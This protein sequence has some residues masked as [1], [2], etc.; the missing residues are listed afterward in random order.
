MSELINNFE[1]FD[2]I[3][4]DIKKVIKRFYVFD[5]EKGYNVLFV[6]LND[7]VFG[8]GSNDC[9]VCGF[10][11]Q[12]VVKGPKII[13]ELCDKSVI[14]FYN[15]STFALALTRDNKL[16]GW[17][18]NQWGQLGLK[19]VNQTKL[20]KPVLIE[21]LN[22]I[23]IKQISCGS[24]HTLVLTSDGMVYGWGNN[25]YGQIG[26]G[27]EL[28]E[29]ISVIVKLESLHKIETIHCSYCSSFALT[30]NGMVYSWGHNNWCHLG[31]ESKQNEC[32]FNPKLIINLQNI[33]SICSSNVNT[34]FLSNE[35]EIY[36]CGVYYDGNNEQCFQ[37]LP[38]VIEFPEDIKL[39][40]TNKLFERSI[41]SINNFKELEEIGILV[42][43]NNV[44]KLNCNEIEITNFKLLQEF[45]SKK[46]QLTYGTIDINNELI[47]E[48][49]AETITERFIETNAP[50]TNEVLKKFT[51]CHN[52]NLNNFFI[53][54]I[55]IFDD[56]NGFN[57]LFVS[58]DD[59]VYGFGSNQWGV[60]GLGHNKNVKDPQIIPELCDKNIQQFYN[61]LGFV[62]GL[63]SD[64]E[65]YGWGRN[66]WL[67]L[68]SETLNK[69]NNKPININIKNQ[70]IKQISCG[71][72]H[73]LV[74]T[75]DRMAYGWGGNSYGQ[76]GCGKELGKTSLITR[77]KSLPIIKSIHCSFCK[78]FA[79]T[80]NGMVYSW[81][82]NDWCY[83][84]HELKQNECIFEP[85]LIINLTQI[86]SIC[87]SNTNTYFLT[88]KGDVYFCG[89]YYDKN[90]IECYQMIPKLMTNKLNIHSLHS[91]NC[92]QQMYSIGCALSDEWVYSL[93]FDSIE[94][95]IYKNLEEFYSNECQ[96][97]YKT[98]Y[99]KLISGI[100]KN[101]IKI[102]GK[103]STII[104]SILIYS[105]FK[106]ENLSKNLLEKMTN[107]IDSGSYGTVYKVEDE[108]NRISAIKI[109]ESTSNIF[110]KNS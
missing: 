86:T 106:I 98:Y 63:T 39:L 91:I 53:K 47:D 66:N 35:S 76:I 19:I 105:F 68:G 14:Q 55:H 93:R 74:L 25:R 61:G 108:D 81:G 43:N 45:Y 3:S 67:Q 7:K 99:L 109:F 36:F 22:D 8:F 79:L 27:K 64:N 11:H 75:S 31:H 82:Y 30:D 78:S 42:I 100:H 80:D 17:G 72:G 65:L 83:L 28:G 10:G 71:S 24:V 32:V 95:T 101:K 4:N 37:L 69:E 110:F 16:Y 84:G 54:Y 33:T 58:M 50:I 62:F 49:I 15:G 40:L 94:K 59:K 60:C 87:S 70:I 9:G 21:D 107:K 96:L 104:K 26:C 57:V 41:H 2:V 29:Y 97:S 20:Y 23:N 1:I 48:T 52:S 102:N 89:L 56:K 13:E 46:Y 92:Y 73:T 88:I 103:I 34:Y 85:K 90:Q 5:D 38:K 44:Y 77:L 12:M 51:I 6:T 18:R